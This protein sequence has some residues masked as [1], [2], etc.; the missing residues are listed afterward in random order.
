MKL[1]PRVNLRQSCSP[2][3]GLNENSPAIYRWDTA[4]FLFKKPAKRATS[5]AHFAGFNRSIGILPS[6]EALG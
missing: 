5:V 2:R 3:S 1:T 6:A 4:S